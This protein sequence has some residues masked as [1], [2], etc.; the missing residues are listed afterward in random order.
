MSK[1][2]TWYQC[3]HPKYRHKYYFNPESGEAKWH[4][5]ITE[6]LPDSVQ[7]LDSV[8]Y[9]GIYNIIYYISFFTSQGWGT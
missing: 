6:R 8:D 9:L 4:L 7:Y 3:T 5:D 2:Y 1:H